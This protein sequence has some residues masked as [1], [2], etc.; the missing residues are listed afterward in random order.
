MPVNIRPAL[1]RLLSWPRQVYLLPVRF[2]RLTLSR[3]IGGQCRFLPTCSQYFIDAVEKKGIVRGTVKGVW[4]LLR[5]H[6]WSKGGY[7]PVE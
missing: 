4:R 5:C 6:P 7:D 2:Y 1:D 3:W